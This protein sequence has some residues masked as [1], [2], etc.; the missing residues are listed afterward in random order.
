MTLTAVTLTAVTLAASIFTNQGMNQD[1]D[2]D[3]KTKTTTK[4]QQNNNKATTKQ[5]RNND[6]SSSNS[7]ARA[8]PRKYSL[9]PYPQKKEND[10]LNN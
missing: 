9:R 1:K 5:Q 3:S 4:Q 2:P 10:V 6:K 7:N 8:S